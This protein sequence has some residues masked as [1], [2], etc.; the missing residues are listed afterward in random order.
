MTTRAVENFAYTATL[1]ANWSPEFGSAGIIATSNLTGS[2]S[3]VAQQA[4][5]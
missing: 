2:L 4:A 5:S 1:N 3:G